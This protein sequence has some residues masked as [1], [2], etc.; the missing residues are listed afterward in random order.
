VL[1]LNFIEVNKNKSIFKIQIFEGYLPNVYFMLISSTNIFYRKE[2][3]L[4]QSLL[5]ILSRC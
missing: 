2:F 3:I 1:H 5:R 4:F